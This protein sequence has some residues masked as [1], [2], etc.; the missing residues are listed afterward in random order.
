ML[1]KARW[2]RAQVVIDLKASVSRF[3][4]RLHCE[5]GKFFATLSNRFRAIKTANFEGESL[6]KP[7][8][9]VM[10]RRNLASAEILKVVL[11]QVTLRVPVAGM[12]I[13]CF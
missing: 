10:L 2:T 11:D 1:Q 13:D 4:A 5:T 3:D 7:F 6:V 12:H 8:V 9:C